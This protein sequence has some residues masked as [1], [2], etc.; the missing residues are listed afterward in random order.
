[1]QF[2]HPWALFSMA[3]L[4]ASVSLSSAPP[5]ATHSLSASSAAND[6]AVIYG[7]LENFELDKKI[8][9]GQFSEVY[10]ARCIF[11]GEIVALK[12]IQVIVF[13][14]VWF[15]GIHKKMLCNGCCKEFKAGNH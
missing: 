10:R 14:G 12:K 6:F 8:G 3:F 1:M 15:L 5:A 7:R 9:K 4:P 11:T 13:L 2:P